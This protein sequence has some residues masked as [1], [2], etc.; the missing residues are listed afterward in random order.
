MKIKLIV[1][2]LLPIFFLAGFAE[3]RG[4]LSE[5]LKPSMID[6]YGDRLFVMD[7]DKVHVYSLKDQKLINSFG[8]KGEGPGE[9]QVSVQMPLRLYAHKEY[10]LIE[11]FNKLLFFTHDGKYIKELRK[12][13]MVNLF[14]PAGN[15]LIARK[16]IQ[17]RDG[18]LST[19]TV[20]IY[21]QKMEELKELFRQDFIQQGAGLKLTL[22][23]G[24]DFLLFSVYNDM[25][26]VDKSVKG[27]YIDVYNSSGE[28][29][30]KINLPYEKKIISSAYKKKVVNELEFD[31]QITGQL[32][33]N[34]ISWKDFSKNFKYV[35]PKYYPS[36][37]SMNIDDGKI[38][39]KTF[40]KEGNK[41]KYI[42]MDLKGKI[43]KTIYLKPTVKKWIM[44]SMMGINLEIIRNGKIYYIIEND[45][46]DWELHIQDIK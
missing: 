4:V 9:F 16:I 40:E 8:R 27:P 45:D 6:I 36:I 21:N 26:F 37:Q 19:S 32:L 33:Q 41:N 5:V 30:Y 7:M 28:K 46:N 38:Y 39:V 25:I 10:V 2:I 35:F 43:L 15:N 34:K 31:P 17:P 24:K 11:S 23:M 18:K 44:S 42:I 22:N 3:N 1:S 20:K 13:P 12:F 14:Q 29:L